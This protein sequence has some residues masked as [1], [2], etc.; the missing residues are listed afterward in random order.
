MI[1]KARAALAR[2]GHQI[3]IGNDL[4]R[5]KYEVVFVERSPPIS[6][7]RLP[8]THS[9]DSGK[10]H[11]PAKSVEDPPL[12]NGEQESQ[13]FKETW[14][15]LDSEARWDDGE[16]REIEELIVRELRGRHQTWIEAGKR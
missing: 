9:T 6:A 14:L 15:K 5:R 16:E 7:D 12:A 11:G 2:Y 8:Q 3:V 4:H 10:D 1:P 13:Q